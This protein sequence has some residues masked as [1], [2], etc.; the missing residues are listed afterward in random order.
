[1]KLFTTT[2]HRDQPLH[3]IDLLKLQ[4]DQSRTTALISMPSLEPGRYGF[5]L[6]FD[7][8]KYPLSQHLCYMRH[9]NDIPLDELS[10]LRFSEMKFYSEPPGVTI[11]PW[12]GWRGIPDMP[13]ISIEIGEQ[14]FEG[15]YNFWSDEFASK[16]LRVFALV[17]IPNS[18]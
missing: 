17:S 7:I 3:R 13:K 6:L 4:V 16:Q 11:G 2:T 12:L 18:K 14:S 1:M 5:H 8:Q 10:E 15:R 9:Q